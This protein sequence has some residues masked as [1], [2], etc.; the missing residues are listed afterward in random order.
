M[1]LASCSHI[2]IFP[3]CPYMV[4]GDLSSSSCHRGTNPIMGPTPMTSSYLITPSSPASRYH[5]I[6]SWGFTIGVGG[7]GTNIQ[8]IIVCLIQ[9]RL[10]RRLG[11]HV[12]LVTRGGG[13][14]A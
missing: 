8:P 7:G 3:P 13:W 4:E 1:G 10:P 11:G 2:A 5:H 9:V 6:R 14:P 12:A